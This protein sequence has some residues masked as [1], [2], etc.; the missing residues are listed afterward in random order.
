MKTRVSIIAVL[1]VFCATMALAV[2]ATI[3]ISPPPA[4]VIQI[5]G[6]NPPSITITR[7]VSDVVTITTP[8]PQGPRGIDG[9]IG[10][11]GA[12]GPTGPQGPAGA[13]GA[14]GPQG[15]TG[16]TGSQGPRGY[17]GYDGS[18]IFT[19]TGAPVSGTGTLSDYYLNTFNGDIY[20]KEG[21]P[22]AW[23]LKGN[24]KGPSGTNGANGTNGTNG[25]N[26]KTVL[27]GIDA[28]GNGLG[29]DGDFYLDTANAHF[30]GPKTAGAWGT[31]IDLVGP[32]G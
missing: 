1:S 23:T 17:D 4:N 2:P 13:T 9:S 22:A 12:P 11:D 15:P 26:G 8:G 20:L 7:P 3:V 5:T 32:Q 19:G 6:Q 25:T 29:V 30:Y 24:L 28:P 31:Y 18:Q 21:S 27:N 10:V 14:T 16:D